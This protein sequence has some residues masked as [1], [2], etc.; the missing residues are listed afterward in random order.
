[1]NINYFI[2]LENNSFKKICY[3][4]YFIL[5][6]CIRTKIT[7]KELNIKILIL[8]F[9]FFVITSSTNNIIFIAVI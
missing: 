4:N 3:W 2:N 8:H 9:P 6:I 1:M 7:L 5:N